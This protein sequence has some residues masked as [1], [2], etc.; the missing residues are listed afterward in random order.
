MTPR[1]RSLLAGLVMILAGCN[2]ASPPTIDPQAQASGAAI[3][4]LAAGKLSTLPTGP[5]YI[6]LVHFAQPS[7][8][9]IKSSQHVPGFVFVEQ[10]TQRLLVVDQPAQDLAAGEAFY[11]TNVTHQHLNHGP[12]TNSWFFLALWSSSARAVPPVDPIA[13]VEFAT[14]DMGPATLPQGAYVQLL[15]QITLSP[16]GRTAAHRFGGLSVLFVLQGALT[17][18]ATGTPAATVAAGHGASY[19]PGVGLQE[20]NESGAP[21]I[22]IELVTTLDGKEF[23]TLL[24]K[25]PSG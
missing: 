19:P 21:A 15:E 6:R 25:S 8:Y 23:V 16:G 7:G 17:V 18:R 22:F 14:P 13:T 3:K 11:L 24:P 4:P 2:S 1:R 9:V 12:G 5:N 20:M 10:G